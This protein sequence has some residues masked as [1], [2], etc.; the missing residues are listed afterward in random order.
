MTCD[1]LHYASDIERN[2]APKDWPR[3]IQQRV[4]PECRSE[5]ETYLRGIAA[6]IRAKR[7][8][9]AKEKTP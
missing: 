1:C 3:A 4:P 9:T 7:A 2:V 5:C 6:R 8:I